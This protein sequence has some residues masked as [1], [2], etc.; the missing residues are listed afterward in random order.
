MHDKVTIRTQMCVPLNSYCDKVK[1][2]NVS[3]TL[4]FEVG[5]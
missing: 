4:T 5:M 3:V 1:V 2:Q